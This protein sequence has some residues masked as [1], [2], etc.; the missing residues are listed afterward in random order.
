MSL[1]SA[2]ARVFARAE[3]SLARQAIAPLEPLPADVKMAS[4]PNDARGV[5]NVTLRSALFGTSRSSRQV[6]LQRVEILSQKP[7]TMRYT[8]PRLDQGDLDVWMTLLHISRDKL[9][10]LT[11]KTSAY[12]LLKLQGKTDAGNN[13]KTLYK[14]LFRLAA[15]TLEINTNRYFYT[16]GLVDSFCRDEDTQELVISLNPEL[17]KLFGPHDFTHVDWSIRRALNSK[18]LAQ[19]LHGFFS[20]HAAPIPISVT[21]IMRMAGS[22]DAS[23]WSQEQNL[24]RALEALQIACNLHCQPFSYALIDGAVHIKRTP[25]KSQSRHIAR[26]NGSAMSRKPYR[27]I[28]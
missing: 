5:P 17:N 23:V 16:G 6:Y 20:S 1:S 26:K 10:G 24:Q 22:L 25:S 14:R 27:T 8:G 18:P 3:A 19:W 4:W 15:A 13:R 2:K 7:T 11:F 12:E 28:G 9:L 21:T